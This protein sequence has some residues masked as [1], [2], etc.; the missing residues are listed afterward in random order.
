[1]LKGKSEPIRA[2][3]FTARVERAAA[4]R[5][6][7]STAR[8]LARLMETSSARTPGRR[9][10]VT[11]GGGRRQN[12]REALFAPGIAPD[13]AVQPDPASPV[14]RLAEIFA[15]LPST[16]LP[17]ALERKPAAAQGLAGLAARLPGRRHDGAGT[18]IPRPHARTG[19][20][21]AALLRAVAH[22]TA[23]ARDREPAVGG[24]GSARV[25]RLPPSVTR[26]PADRR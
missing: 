24:R 11:R 6:G 20:A 2:G 15:Q 14:R 3:G 19:F 22:H 25:S 4:R 8:R 26:A 16:W 18:S 1:M 12:L 10:D 5:R 9:G 21:A 7:S 13:P 17:Q 23:R